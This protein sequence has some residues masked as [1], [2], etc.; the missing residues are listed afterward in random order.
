MREEITEISKELAFYLKQRKSLREPERWLGGCSREMQLDSSAPTWCLTTIYNSSFWRP[1][2][3]SWP[4]RTPG[5]GMGH[6]ADI[7]S[8][9]TYK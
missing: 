9:K 2:A 7:Y 1:N 3:L 6:D 8:G 5:M 4:L